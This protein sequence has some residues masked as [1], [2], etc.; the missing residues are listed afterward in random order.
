MIVLTKGNTSESFVVT[1]N[2]KRTLATGYYLFLFTHFTTRNI[3]AKIYA[4]AEDDSSYPDRYN[5]FEINTQSLFGGGPVGQ[6]FY[7]V[8][9][10][11]SPSNTDP[12]GLTQVECGVM[13]LNP[14]VEFEREQYDIN[15]TF[16]QY[17]G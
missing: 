10:Q 12:E 8:Y 4:F 11:E 14:Q 7:Q 13:V 1:L 16:K 3:V 6:W 15:T 2:E 9:E 17:A 5:S